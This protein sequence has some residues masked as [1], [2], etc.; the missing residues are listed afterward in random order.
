VRLFSSFG[1]FRTFKSNYVA[2]ADDKASLPDYSRYGNLV[3]G[4]ACPSDNC[5]RPLF[6]KRASAIGFVKYLKN[7][8][9]FAPS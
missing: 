2:S 9:D 6:D 5:E 8:E 7:I 4:C 3:E 1:E